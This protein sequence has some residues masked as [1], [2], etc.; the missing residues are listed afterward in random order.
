MVY[1]LNRT[2]NDFTRT[3][4]DRESIYKRKFGTLYFGYNNN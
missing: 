1:S 2:F 4:I 3:S